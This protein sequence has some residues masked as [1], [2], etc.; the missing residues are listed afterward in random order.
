MTSDCRRAPLGCK[1]IRHSPAALE[2]R[3]GTNPGQNPGDHEMSHAEQSVEYATM[4]RGELLYGYEAIADYLGLTVREVRHQV[5]VN[6]LPIFKLGR[7]VTAR[8]RTLHRWLDE[9]ERKQ[10]QPKKDPDP[11][12]RIPLRRYG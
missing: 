12:P 10:R 6:K 4:H 9:Q 8:V 3:A 5:E 11:R 2:S 1:G 7:S